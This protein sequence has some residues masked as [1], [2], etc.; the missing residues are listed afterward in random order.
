MS[1]Q[2]QYYPPDMYDS[3]VKMN[4]YYQ[5]SHT[6]LNS[7]DNH[8]DE[9]DAGGEHILFVYNIGTD[10]DEADLIQLFGNFGHV[11]DVR[12]VRRPETGM[13]LLSKCFLSDLLMNHIFS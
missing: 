6:S 1:P 3:Y 11:L 13:R 8:Y 4:Q 5:P 2:A 12:L 7:Y 10:P 9:S